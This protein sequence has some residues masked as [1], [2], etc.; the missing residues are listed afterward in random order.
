MKCNV[1]S[2]TNKSAGSIELDD[3]IFGL[4]VRKDLLARAVNWQLAKRR[5]G[6]HKVKQR[7]EVIGSTAKPF[8]QKGGGRARQGDKK[9]PHMRGGGVA[10]GPVV[11]SHQ[12]NLT[13][14]LRALA[15]KTALSSKMAIGKLVVIDK[16]NLKSKKTSDLDKQLGKLNWGKALIIDGA[17]LD[18]N[19]KL[20]V[21]NIANVDVLPSC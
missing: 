18:Q 14:K 10:F 4:E 7:S 19:F 20:A 6:N 13:K 3:L 16:I 5:A 12:H 17:D 11:R 21:R 8:N 15:L 2:L 1:V 9:A